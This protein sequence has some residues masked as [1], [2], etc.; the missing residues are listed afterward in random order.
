MYCTIG[1]AASPKQRRRA[2]GPVVD[3][4]AVHDDEAAEAFRDAKDAIRNLAALDKIRQHHVGR[5]FLGF[6]EFVLAGQDR[7]AEVERGPVA[8]RV[9]DHVPVGPG[10][11]CR[12]GPLQ[13][14][15]H[16]GGRDGGAKDDGAGRQ[17]IAVADDALSHVRIDAVGA[18]QR[19]R[20]N[21]LAG[22]QRHRYAGAFQLK[23]HH[24]AIS[25]Q[26]DQFVR[27]AGIEQGTVNMRAMGNRV[28][29][30]EAPLEPRVAGDVGDLLAGDGIHHQEPLDHQ[31]V[32]LRRRADAERIEHRKRV[33]RNM[34]ADADLAEFAR[35]LQHQAT[36][37]PTRQRQRAGEPADAAACDGDR[38]RVAC[39]R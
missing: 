28:G 37:S 14:L 35:L 8:D 4:L 19:G 27:A 2:H 25:A 31:R 15:R 39:C 6:A 3:R 33:R 29:V 22:V 23:A 11:E 9:I 16:L 7:A 32:L 21:A 20:G 12:V 10:P 38:L 26:L 34:E 17:R 18:D 36:E 13:I 1:C 5:E 30:A 24:A